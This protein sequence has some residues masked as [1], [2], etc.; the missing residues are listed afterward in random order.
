[1][2]IGDPVYL[3]PVGNR[4]RR[5]NKREQLEAVKQSTIAHIGRKY[6]TLSDAWYGKF[7]I[8]SRLQHTQYTSDWMFYLSMDELNRE[9][10]MLAM[11][12]EIKTYFY[13]APYDRSPLT[14]EQAK[15]IHDII[16][17]NQTK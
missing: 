3:K 8:E 2:N 9:L 16:F 13:N 5:M 12:D 7:E 15:Q 10:E 6:I 11:W 14:L 17:L 1:M 4:A